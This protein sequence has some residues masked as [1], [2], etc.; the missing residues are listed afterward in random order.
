MGRF[1]KWY[2][3]HKRAHRI[4]MR[5]IETEENIAKVGAALLGGLFKR[6]P[7]REDPIYYDPSKWTGRPN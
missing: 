4:G 5:W 2:R 1:L 3:R 6:R 7:K